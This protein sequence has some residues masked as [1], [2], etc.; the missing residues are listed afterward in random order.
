[1]SLQP[2]LDCGTPTSG[3]RCPKHAAPRQ[4]AD[5]ERRNA[6]RRVHRRTTAH[7]RRLRAAVLARDAHLCRLQLAGCT[8]RATSVHLNPELGGRHDLAGPADCLSAC[9]HC[10][11]VID[12][13]R[14]GGRGH[15]GTRSESAT[16]RSRSTF[17]CLSLG[18]R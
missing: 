12:G 18:A 16:P 10:H 9:A 5:S 14:T 15:D 7:W 4:A 1:M 3:S 6:K 2:C 8:T 11:G 13:A 17:L